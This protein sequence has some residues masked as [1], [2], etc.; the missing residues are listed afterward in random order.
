MVL[1][2]CVQFKH[3]P[4]YLEWAPVNVFESPAAQPVNSEQSQSRKDDKVCSLPAYVSH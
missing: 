2:V 1:C 4:L 3:V